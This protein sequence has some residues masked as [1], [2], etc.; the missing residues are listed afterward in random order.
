MRVAAGQMASKLKRKYENLKM[1]IRMAEA[2]A[3]NG[4]KLI[5]FPELALT[6]LM[7]SGLEDASSMA[8]EVPGPSTKK[9]IF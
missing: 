9:I 6:G 8:E 7:Y 4:V 1:L 5:A 3:D 2:A